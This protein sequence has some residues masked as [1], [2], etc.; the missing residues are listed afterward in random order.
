MPAAKGATPTVF[1]YDLRNQQHRETSGGPS[2]T[3]TSEAI[4]PNNDIEET[5]N[6]S[7]QVDT[8][9]QSSLQVSEEE[10]AM[11]TDKLRIDKYSGTLTLWNFLS[12]LW[13]VLLV[14]T[15]A[16]ST[17]NDQDI[18][19]RINYGVIFQPMTKVQFATEYWLHTYQLDIPSSFHLKAI[20]GCYHNNSTCQLVK[21]FQSQVNSI[22]MRCS[23]MLNE[24]LFQ[25]NQLLPT[26]FSPK[27]QRSKLALLGFIGHLSKS[28]FGTATSDDVNIL[29]KHINALTKHESIIGNALT[30]HQHKLTSFMASVDTRFTN[31]LSG[32]KL[33]HEEIKYATAS[34][35]ES[36]Q[37]L[38][39]AYISLSS[40]ILHQIEQAALIEHKL[41]EFKF[42]VL[43]LVQGKLSPLL[44]SPAILTTT[45]NHIKHILHNKYNG[46]KLLDGNTNFYYNHGKF[47]YAKT[48][49]NKLYVTVKFPLAASDTTFNL[50]R[51]VSLPIPVN[52]S[53]SH[54]TQLL[55]LSPL[56]AISTNKQFSTILDSEQLSQ[57]Y[58]SDTLHCPFRMS[59]Q[60]RTHTSCE[61][62][63]YHNSKDEIKSHC[64]FRFLLHEKKSQLIEITPSKLLV[65]N[66]PLLTLTCPEGQK[67]ISGCTFCMISLPCLCSVTTANM[68][69]PSHL[70]TCQNMS[71]QNVTYLHPVNLALLQHFF[72]DSALETIAGNTFYNKPISVHIPDFHLYQNKFDNVI[73]N[74]HKDHLN[75]KRMAKRVKKNEVI[76]Q[77]LTEC[78]LDG[79]INRLIFPYNSLCLL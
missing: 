20:R 33:N 58:G 39:N 52:E 48:K 78:L 64:N 79:K 37:N 75:L 3:N 15:M 62:A 11:S 77:G 50:Y 63:L 21:L 45:I 16:A 69:F 9:V 12:L 19:Q 54:A 8:V 13:L 25:I 23:T 22:K 6:P 31:A 17:P 46:F 72:E 34:I 55:N 24:T 71:H 30:E 2:S 42:G 1:P 14:P 38:K 73:A 29:A 66:T 10:P 43:D 44:I 61:M 51:I 47:L 35:Q 56:I 7:A 49:S 59:L 27:G 60:T 76:F 4:P 57:C 53:T 68:L 40:V 26:T 70:G 65:Y 32:I 36:F 28:L 67:I 18:I 5:N 74:D 41:Q